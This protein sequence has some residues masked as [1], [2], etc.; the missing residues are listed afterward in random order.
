MHY[1]INCSLF[2]VTSYGNQYLII[3]VS[4]YFRSGPWLFPISYH[5]V[6]YK[7]CYYGYVYGGGGKKKPTPIQ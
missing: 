4:V 2:A 5:V 1:L 3:G 7:S 6:D